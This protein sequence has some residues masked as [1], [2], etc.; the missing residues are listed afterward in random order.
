MT[1]AKQEL[2]SLKTCLLKNQANG[3]LLQIQWFLHSSAITTS[4]NCIKV[5]IISLIINYRNLKYKLEFNN[6]RWFEQYQYVCLAG[7]AS[8]LHASFKKSNWV[9]YQ[10]ERGRNQRISFHQW[11]Q[12]FTLS[13]EHYHFRRNTGFFCKII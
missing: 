5:T 12:I 7:D 11:L 6:R 2:Q 1:G 4:L 13:L 9:N 3:V 8:I 10:R